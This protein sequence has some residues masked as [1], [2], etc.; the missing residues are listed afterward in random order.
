MKRLLGLCSVLLALASQPSFALSAAGESSLQ[1]V[2]TRWAEINYQLPAAQREAAFAKLAAEAER[3]VAGEP[4]AAELHIWHGI[5]LSTWAGAKGGLGALGL[6]KQAKA[7]LEKAIELDAQALDGSA[8]TSLASL[9]YQ[10]PGWPIGFGDEDKAEALF[11]QALALNPN[12]IDPNYFHGDFLLRQKRYGEARA[13]LEKA[14]A[15]PARPGREVAD[16]GRRDEARALLA[17]V[18]EKLE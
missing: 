16:A 11:Q 18:K 14:L 8:Y 5:V 6:V 12:G 17:Q 3:A 2:Q 7:E 9:Y 1:Q 10:V 13:A 15:A 4:Q